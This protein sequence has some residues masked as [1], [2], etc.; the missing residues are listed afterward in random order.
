MVIP[1]SGH[2]YSGI[3][4]ERMIK[5][6]SPA[7]GT[8]LYRLGNYTQG[9]PTKER[10]LPHDFGPDAEPETCFYSGIVGLPAI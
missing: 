9:A 4:L 5:W 10:T 1:V 3:R 7:S 6:V 2:L 8:A